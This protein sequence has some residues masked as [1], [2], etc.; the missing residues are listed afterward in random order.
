MKMRSMP[1]FMC[2][3]C[4]A[5]FL[6]LHQKVQVYSEAYRLSKNYRMCNNLADTRDYLT[7]TYAK[8]TSVAVLSQWA[9]ENKYGFVGKEKML[10][11]QFRKRRQQ[12]TGQFV[13]VVNNVLGIST[14][15]ATAM[16][17]DR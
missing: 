11:V 10:A 3:V 5:V 17:Q 12:P 13:R 6:R 4:A 16:T 9:D 14:A 1:V 15:T 7:Y 2:L 8:H